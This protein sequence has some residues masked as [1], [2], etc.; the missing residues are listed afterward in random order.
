LISIKSLTN[1]INDYKHLKKIKN[2][3][4]TDNL[5]RI[6]ALILIK[7]LKMNYRFNQIIFNKQNNHTK[8]SKV[9]IE[10]KI[11]LM[12]LKNIIIQMNRMRIY[13]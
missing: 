8:K 3:I 10:L 11:K 4:A 5:C 13:K 12:Y 1:Q 2:R 6:K 9:Y 7:T